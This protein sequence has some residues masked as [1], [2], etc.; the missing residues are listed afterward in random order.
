MKE[1]NEESMK[2]NICGIIFYLNDYKQLMRMIRI[3][4]RFE[5]SV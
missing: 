5:Y 3:K 2:L 4:I 1:E